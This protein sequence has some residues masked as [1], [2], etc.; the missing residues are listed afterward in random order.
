[1]IQSDNSREEDEV[2]LEDEE[3]DM[4]DLDPVKEVHMTNS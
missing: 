4:R 2:D 3:E 1:M